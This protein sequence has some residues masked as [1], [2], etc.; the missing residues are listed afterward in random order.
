MRYLKNSSGYTHIFEVV[1]LNGMCANVPRCT[2][3][4]YIQ[5]VSE[6]SKMAAG[7]PEVLI[8]RKLFEV[9]EKFQRLHP[10]FQGRLT[11]WDYSQHCSTSADT[12]NRNGGA[13]I[14]SKSKMAA[15]KAGLP[16]I[17][18]ENIVQINFLLD[19]IIFLRKI[20]LVM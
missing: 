5:D 10:G 4:L 11:D 8:T 1:Y 13:V 6:K 20:G 3:P 14:G 18:G 17:Q 15:V 2:I 12:E 16:D 9:S 19:F 7:K